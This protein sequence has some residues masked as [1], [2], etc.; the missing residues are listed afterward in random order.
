MALRRL[1]LEDRRLGIQSEIDGRGLE[2]GAVVPEE[3]QT[4]LPVFPER[5]GEAQAAGA[6]VEGL[7]IRSAIQAAAAEVEREGPAGFHRVVETQAA[8]HEEAV[9]GLPF[10]EPVEAAEDRKSTRLNS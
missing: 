4:V 6:L 10:R 9:Q 7:L 3:S 2:G 1:G 5:P 8:F